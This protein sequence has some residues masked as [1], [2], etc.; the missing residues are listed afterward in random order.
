MAFGAFA[1]RSPFLNE[2][3]HQSIE[4]LTP[5]IIIVLTDATSIGD[6]ALLKSTKSQVVGKLLNHPVPHLLRLGGCIV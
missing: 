1:A 5:S 4:M 3:L 6:S 2:T